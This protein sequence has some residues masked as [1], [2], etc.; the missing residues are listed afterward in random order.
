[1]YGECR[2]NVALVM[3]A[4]SSSLSGAGCMGG[5]GGSDRRR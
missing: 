2:G 5:E 4:V 3:S 1:M